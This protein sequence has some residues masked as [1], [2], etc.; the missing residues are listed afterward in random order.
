MIKQVEFQHARF[1]VFMGTKL[2]TESSGFGLFPSR[3]LAEPSVHGAEG[4]VV[5][6]RSVQLKAM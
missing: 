4:I 2:P 6:Q 1:Y 3:Y 5:S